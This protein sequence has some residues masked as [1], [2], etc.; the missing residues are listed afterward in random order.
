MTITT[1]IALG[2]LAALAAALALGFV[3]ST[4][5]SR[6]ELDAVRAAHRRALAEVT[7]HLPGLTVSA[8]PDEGWAT[9]T[10]KRPGVTL[11]LSAAAALGRT[12]FIRYRTRLLALP[13]GE[14]FALPGGVRELRLRWP[15]PGVAPEGLDALGLS[16]ELVARLGALCLELELRPDAL[17]L[18][19][20]PGRDEA[21][22][23]YSYGLHLLLLP[24]ALGA[25]LTLGEE[26]AAALPRQGGRE[27]AR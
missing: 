7:E 15:R 17:C 2:L 10:G 14:R 24:P 9:L 22:Q 3:R 19:A 8:P 16:D 21:V 26:L 1:A 20:R 4:R 12:T 5:R 11:E 13:R 18:W 25:L 27:V 23:R 6:A